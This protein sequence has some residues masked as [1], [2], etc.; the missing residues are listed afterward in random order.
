[1]CSLNNLRLSDCRR[2]VCSLNNLRL[3][4]CR[5]NLNAFLLWSERVTR[6][7]RNVP[8]NTARDRHGRN[9]R[10]AG[11][12]ALAG[13]QQA[14]AAGSVEDSASEV[15]L[16]VVELRAQ[17]GKLAAACTAC[18]GDSEN[19][20][21]NRCNLQT[22][23]M[24][25][26]RR[27]IEDDDHVAF[28]RSLDQRLQARARQWP[29]GAGSTGEHPNTDAAACVLDCLTSSWKVLVGAEVVVQTNLANQSE[30]LIHHDVATIGVY[31][32]HISSGLCH[33]KCEVDR[34]RGTTLVLVGADDSDRVHHPAIAGSKRCC[35]NTAEGFGAGGVCAHCG[36]E[37]WT[38]LSDTRN[39]A[40]DR[41]TEVVLK[42]VCTSDTAVKAVETDRNH[43][44][45]QETHERA[46]DYSQQ[47]WDAPASRFGDGWVA[48]EASY[49]TRSAGEIGEL[50]YDRCPAALDGAKT[51]FQ[52]FKVDRLFV[53]QEKLST[54]GIEAAIEFFS[55]F[56]EDG[57]LLRTVCLLTISTE[58]EVCVSGKKDDCLG[59]FCGLP[60]VGELQDLV[61][62]AVI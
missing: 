56:L 46:G 25:E 52:H 10:D 39:I 14:E 31:D 8:G 40:Q 38:V 55:E 17:L 7:V 19:R 59:L 23:S 58:R 13:R 41:Y 2:N 5:R 16:H 36:D 29:F 61:S 32:Q 1:M 35:R 37:S 11:D 50:V 30:D 53:R 34:R 12:V 62:A 51:A 24:S 47:E 42:F 48:E 18:G 3:S 44:A 27:G 43:C 28:G 54:Y 20:V 45:E 15:R 26:C 57:D 4:D 6:S 49:V 9:L 22:A 21:G 60:L 33:G